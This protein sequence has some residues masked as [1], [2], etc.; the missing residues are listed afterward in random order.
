MAEKPGNNPLIQKIEAL[1]KQLQER[2]RAEEVLLE[3]QKRYER[4]VNT[5][6]CPLYDYV[7]WPDSRNRFIYIS[8]QCKKIFELEAES[9]MDNAYLL[10]NMVVPED[11]E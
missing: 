3:Y 5:I 7:R 11:L 6:P 4:L 9:I 1:E 2:Q 8:P 10:W